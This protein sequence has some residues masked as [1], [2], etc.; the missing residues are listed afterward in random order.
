MSTRDDTRRSSHAGMRTGIRVATPRRRLAPRRSA[1]SNWRSVMLRQLPG[2]RAGP[3]RAARRARRRVRLACVLFHAMTGSAPFRRPSSVE[4]LTAH[5][6]EPVPSAH[7][8]CRDLPPAVDAVLARGLAKAPGDRP[9]S[10]G[11]LVAQ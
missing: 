2:A 9:P 1:R 4:T 5:L 10:A 7:A 3:R 6:H 8:W 11:E